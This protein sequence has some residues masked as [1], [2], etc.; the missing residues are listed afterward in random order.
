MKRWNITKGLSEPPNQ[1]YKTTQLDG[2]TVAR[3]T[4]KSPDTIVFLQQPNHIILKA[5]PPP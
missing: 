5:S 3:A 1:V 2:R 4:A